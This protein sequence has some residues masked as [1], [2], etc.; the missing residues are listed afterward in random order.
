[1]ALG[2]AADP[3]GDADMAANPAT[4]AA[5]KHPMFV[6]QGARDWLTSTNNFDPAPVKASYPES[7]HGMS[8][9]Q[10]A[11]A[12]RVGPVMIGAYHAS[13][14]RIKS[15]IIASIAPSSAPYVAPSCASPCV[16]SGFGDP[17]ERTELRTGVVLA[18]ERG[19]LAFGVGA[20]LQR[21]TERVE[22]ERSF[23]SQ[24][25][26]VTLQEDRLFQQIN[27]RVVVPNAGLRW[28][29]TPRIALAAAYNGAGSLTRTTS[30]CLA[31]APGSRE[32]PGTCRS[33]VVPLASSTERQP[34]AWRTSASFAATE[35]LRLVAE[36]VR[37]R[38][39]NLADD[40]D[41]IF[42]EA[43]RLPYHDVTELHAG[44]EYKLRPVALRIGWWR[45]PSRANSLPRL[46]TSVTH[47]T[48]GAG[49]NFGRTRF[50]VAYDHASM[51]TQRHA[52]A[53]ITFGL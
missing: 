6:V 13:E 15:L 12:A 43:R 21:V 11:A 38:Y 28:R 48:F 4:L 33:V 39:S 25:A 2:G 9:S 16:I 44:A 36:G 32:A 22:I 45:D 47:Y 17:F 31:G 30:V 41:T 14:P 35:R 23:L 18:W 27:D 8:L 34:D 5:I 51:A 53:G 19:P 20:E 1:M 7:L 42:G 52:A 50:D 3:L 40:Q 46:D 49:I 29:V 24:S 10:I 26:V 37:R